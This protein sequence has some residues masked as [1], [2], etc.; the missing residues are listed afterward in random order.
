MANS[1]V[2]VYAVYAPCIGITSIMNPS[3]AAIITKNAKTPEDVS[4]SMST[5]MAVVA[6][7]Q[8]AASFL[9]ALI[10]RALPEDKLYITFIISATFA[11]PMFILSLYLRHVI[12]RE[13]EEEYA[14]DKLSAEEKGIA[15]LLHKKY[16]K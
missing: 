13:E 6:V 3:L 9:A 8:A 14:S 1:K 16:G 10:F 5:V 2:L 11:V 7:L 15:P 4:L 12:K